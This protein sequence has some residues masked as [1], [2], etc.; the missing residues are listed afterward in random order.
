MLREHGVDARRRG[1][2]RERARPSTSPSTARS[3]HSRSRPSRRCSPTTPASSSRRRASARRWSAPTSSPP[4]RRARSSSSTASRSST[5]GSASSRC[6]SA[7]S[8]EDI[9]Q[10]GAGKA[11]PNGR[12]DVAMIQSLVRKGSVADL[13]AGYGQVIVDEC[14][15]CPAVTFERVLAEVKARYVVGLTATPQRRDGHHPILE[16]QL[17][18]V[19]FA[20]DAKSQAA[21][22]PFDHRLVV[23]ETGF[24]LDRHARGRRH[25]GALRRA[26]R[27]PAPQRPHPQRRDASPRGEAVADPAHRA[28]GSPGALRRAAA[29]LHPPPGRAPRRHEAQ[30]AARGDRPARRRSPT[31]RSGCSSRP[32]DTSARASTTPGSTPCSWRCRSR[33]RARSSSTPAACTGSTPARP[34]SGSTTT[35]TAPC[36]C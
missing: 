25:P 3:R 2:A 13:V 16:M 1:R 31:A 27:G 24:L 23:R 20:V 35:W 7:S 29:E 36:R 22:R 8:P 5:S 21:R 6:S 9:G 10:I 17:G 14:H 34:R 12:L 26:R 28:A 4:A 15:H 11:K 30:G 18:P 19:R 32:A 33:G